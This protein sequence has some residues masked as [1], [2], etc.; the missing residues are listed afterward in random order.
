MDPTLRFALFGAGLWARFQL[1]GWLETG[2]AECVAI[3]DRNADR[4]R[5]LSAEFGIPGVYEDAASLYAAERLD[6][7]DVC[8]SADTHAQL[9]Y[10]AALHG[11]PVVCQKPM[12]ENLAEAERMVA[13]CRTAGVQLLV[14]ENW[15][16]QTP[17]RRLD[18]ML[19]AG[20]IGEPFRARIR[21]VSGF[22]VFANQPFLRHLKQF[23]LIDV[24]SHILDVV[25]FL[26]GEAE[27]VY[28]Q[29]SRIQPDITGEDVATVLV[30]MKS[31]MVVTCEMGYP[32]SPH[33]DDAFPQTFV[34]VEGSGGS[35]SLSRNYRIR[36]VDRAGTH[37]EYAVPQRYSWAN[38]AYDIVHSSIVPCQQNLLN[39]LR[40]IESAETD[41]DDNLRT[42]RLVH[43]AYDS[44]ER[45][46]VV[47]L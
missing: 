27:T 30:R 9:V 42:V 24:G 11:L 37:D 19:R 29:T 3:C 2:G 40:G 32:G 14:N 43:A 8:T 22:P 33:E 15:R 6:F 12:A 4:A 13:A 18:S 41:G 1:E 44:A 7:V 28:C 21:M 45:N 31:G 10:D 26:F 20:R 35:I 47:R 39:A 17:I 38:P 5:Q 16:W 25:R 46:E 23:L 34:F 36:V